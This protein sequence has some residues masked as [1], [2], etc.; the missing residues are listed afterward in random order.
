MSKMNKI[1]IG[2]KAVQNATNIAVSNYSFI[3]LNM[4]GMI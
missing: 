2:D 4:C 3:K 1:S